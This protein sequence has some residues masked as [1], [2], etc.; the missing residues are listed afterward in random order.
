MN[1]KSDILY[2]SEK[3]MTTSIVVFFTNESIN[4]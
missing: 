2:H 4:K 1:Y 3:N